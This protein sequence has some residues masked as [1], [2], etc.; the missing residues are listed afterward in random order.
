M[1]EWESTLQRLWRENTRTSTVTHVERVAPSDG[2]SEEWPDWTPSALVESLAAAGISAPWSHQVAAA[3]LA[4]AGGNVIIS[5]GTA[6]GKSLAFLL[7]CAEAVED[8]GTVLYL[9]P[10]KA[11]AAD[12]LRSVR[13]LALPGLRAATYD[14]D[15]PRDERTWIRSHANYVLT[16]P[17]MLHRGI[18]RRHAAWAG[19]LRRLR[20]VVIDEAHRYRGVFGSHVAQ[21]VRRLRR[22]CARHRGEPVFILASATTGTPEESAERLTGLPV[23]AVSVDRSPRPALSFAL[24]EPDLTEARGERGAPVRRTATAEAAD[25]LAALAA[26]GVRTLA[27]ARSRQGA[28]VI[29]MSAQ[30]ILADT[31]SHDL[32]R[33]VAAYRG[34]YL[35][36]ERRELEEALRTGELRALAATNALELGVDITGLDAVLI[37]GWP[38]TLA[39]LWQQAGRAGRRGDHALAVFIARDDPLDTYLAHHPDAIFGRPMEAVVL[40]PDNPYV[41]GPHL[42]AAAEEIALTEDDLPVFGPAAEGVLADLVRRGLL[43]RRPRGWFWAHK[44]P[45]ADLAD[46]R[47]AGGAPVQIVDAGSGQLLG[48]I[49]DAAAHGAVHEGAVYLHQGQTYVVDRLDLDDEVALVHAEDP[50]YSTW[51]REVTEIEVR[52]ALREEEWGAAATVHFGEVRV[53]RQ[54]VGYLKRDVRTGAVLGEQPL[55]LPERTLHT[56]AVWWTLSPDAEKRLLA[57]A[58]EL[59]GAAHAAEHA[60]IGLLPLFATCD[61]WD[62]G[63]VS[64]ALHA[65]TGR[66]TVFVYD[67]HEGGAGFAERGFAAAREWLAA[68]REAIANCECR[69]GCPSCIQSPKC[70][71]GNDPLDKDGALRLLGEVLSG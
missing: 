44:E 48:T 18:L 38:G 21:I 37:T 6:S 41:L 34:G 58:V 55:D 3:D 28:E 10:T 65:D 43:R 47:G 35:A 39:S 22:V 54:V 25:L 2:V 52:S 4:R 27:F 46:I 68:T 60:A 56:R 12:Q 51:S 19:F 70:G 45:A 13:E 26:D 66:L 33:R 1:H 7:P 42:C 14:G 36:G 50:P 57:D 59:R 5:T 49:D 20:Y 40:D 24:V 16:N 23:R 63:G 71:S 8:G 11:L 62:I 9:S 61:R 29:A 15:T 64:T 17:D 69:D 31:R 67:G 32:A 30:R 53:T